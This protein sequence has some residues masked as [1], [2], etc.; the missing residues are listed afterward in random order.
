MSTSPLNKAVTR[1]VKMLS[2]AWD[3]NQG[4][5]A[6]VLDMTQAAVS[7]K[8]SNKSN[9][10]L[11]EIELLAA[12]YGVPPAA[13]LSDARHLVSTSAEWTPGRNNDTNTL[14]I[15][16]F[17]DML[18]GADFWEEHAREPVLNAA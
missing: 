12:H 2:A 15:F 17:A 10:H 3:E 18:A 6:G 5:I 16:N 4:D 7:R 8:M 11:D 14:P 1:V 9:W 13:F